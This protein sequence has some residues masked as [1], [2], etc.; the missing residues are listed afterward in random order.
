[1]QVSCNII[2]DAL[3]LLT[4]STYEYIFYPYDIKREYATASCS[5]SL[6]SPS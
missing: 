5:T 2:N 3:D 4:I 6:A 1:M